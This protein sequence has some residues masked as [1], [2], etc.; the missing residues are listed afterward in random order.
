MRT[1]ILHVVGLLL[2][3]MPLHEPRV[4]RGAAH[5][6]AEGSDSTMC[7]SNSGTVMSWGGDRLTTAMIHKR[8]SVI[9][10]EH[11]TA[12]TCVHTLISSRS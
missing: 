5:T 7:C 3:S 6:P 10:D 8:F 9:G 12:C 4:F 1:L 11:V 2:V